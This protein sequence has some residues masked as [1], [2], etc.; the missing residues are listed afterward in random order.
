MT[1]SDPRGGD[2]MPEPWVVWS[3]EHDAWWGANHCG[4]YTSLLSA[5]V[6]TEAAARQI[7]QRAAGLTSA[8]CRPERALSLR[9]ALDEAVAAQRGASD[10][11]LAHLLTALRE[12]REARDEALDADR[13]AMRAYDE[14]CRAHNKAVAALRASES[15]VGELERRHERTMREVRTAKEIIHAAWPDANGKDPLSI[16]LCRA[17]QALPHVSEGSVAMASSSSEKAPPP[18]SDAPAAPTPTGERSLAM[19]LADL[20]ALAMEYQRAGGL[21][22]AADG[23]MTVEGV[24]RCNDAMI[25]VRDDILRRVAPAPDAPVAGEPT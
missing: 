15:R 4:Y 13:E 22:F 16:A 5:G 12:V 14:E 10:T 20:I 24:A 18:P 7:E 21:L 6:Y 3:F 9:T 25:A 1:A 17:F 11:V 19:M 2:T 8:D 23:E